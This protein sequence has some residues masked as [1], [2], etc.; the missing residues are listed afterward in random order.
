MCVCVYAYI[1]INIDI[2]MF[3]DFKLKCYNR[4]FSV[5]IHFLSLLLG[6]HYRPSRYSQ[7]VDSYV[8]VLLTSLLL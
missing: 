8:S 7:L 6:Q 4:T 5:L 3:I 1:N 2:N